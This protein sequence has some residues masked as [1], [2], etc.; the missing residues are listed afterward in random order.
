MQFKE[1]CWRAVK[2]E[3]YKFL[4]TTAC[5]TKFKQKCKLPIMPLKLIC[6]KTTETRPF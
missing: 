5:M 1:K 4:F 6:V 2:I 3:I